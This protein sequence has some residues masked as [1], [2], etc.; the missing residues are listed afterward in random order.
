MGYH[1][2]QGLFIHG[3]LQMWSQSSVLWHKLGLQEEE[4]EEE[5]EGGC[6]ETCREFAPSL[7]CILLSGPLL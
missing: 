3:R 4:E 5:E 2:N 6:G 1:L 7:S